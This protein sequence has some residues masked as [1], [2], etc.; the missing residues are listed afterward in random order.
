MRTDR[1]TRRSLMPA[2][3][4]PTDPS[5]ENLRKQAKA[6]LRSVRDGDWQTLGAVREFHP[7]GDEALGGFSLADAQL[8]VARGYGFESWPKLKQHLE[9]PSRSRVE[10]LIR[11]AV[12]DYD[13][14]R[15]A[16]AEEE[17]RMVA[18]H[19]ELARADTYPAAPVSRIAET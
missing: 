3:S 16:H 2:R 19:P 1:R 17:R 18:D 15:P 13:Q 14:W 5:L 11:L 10:K 6:L 4:L 9:T 8:V 12:L 7:R